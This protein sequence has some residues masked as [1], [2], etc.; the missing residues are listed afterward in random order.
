MHRPDMALVLALAALSAFAAGG[1]AAEDARPPFDY[2]WGKAYHILPQTHNEESGYFSLCEGLDGKIYVGTAKYNVNAYL[3]E[4]DPE[5]ERQRVVVDVHELC[6]LE[7]EGYAAQAK[8]HTPNFVGPSGTIYFGS[9]QG[10]RLEGDT[11]QYPGGY[12][13]TYD[14]EQG[15]GECL[16]MPEPGDGIVDVV[17][18][19]E[20]GILYVATCMRRRWILFDRASGASRRLGPVLAPF[21]TTLVDGRG[22]ANALTDHFQLAQYDPAADRLTVRDMVVDGEKFSPQRASAVPTWRLAADGRTAYLILMDDPTLIEMDLLSEGPVVRAK[23]HGKMIEGEGFDSRCALSFGP[24]GRLYAV[25]RVNNETGF[26]GGYLHHVLRFDPETHATRDLGVLAVKNPDFFDFGPRADGT[27]A[28]GSH[29]YHTLA[30]GTLTPLHNHLAMIVTRDGTMYVT[31]LY[32]F[33][34]LQIT[35]LRAAASY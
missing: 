31:I 7:A 28:T 9:M 18:D 8:I 10:Y 22:R 30:D 19:E 29:G 20:R 33:T 16:G 17:A 13:M 12:L 14:P 21:A 11:S 6:G 27:R 15:R 32:P 35:Q 34:L 5:T 1:L 4:F 25:V 26:G 23:S 24:E 3:V 2:V